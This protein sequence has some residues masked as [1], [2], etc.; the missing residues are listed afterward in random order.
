MRDWEAVISVLGPDLT[1]QQWAQRMGCSAEEVRTMARVCGV[2][3]REAEQES[4]I[5]ELVTALIDLR[6]EADRWRSLALEGS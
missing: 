6:D 4:L 5:D 2:V 3:V 1:V